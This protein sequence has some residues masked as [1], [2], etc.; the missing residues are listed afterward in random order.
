MAEPERN[1]PCPC[2]SGKKYKKCC[3][4]RS[5][6]GGDPDHLLARA[7]QAFETG[8]SAD[9]LALGRALLRRVPGSVPGH[10]L[11]GLALYRN[12]DAGQARRHLEQALQL[13]PG[14]AQIHS[15]LTLVLQ[16]LGDLDAAER[17]ALRA[18]ALDPAL[19]DAHNNLGNVLKAKGLADEAI[20]H[21]RAATTADPGNPLFLVNLGSLLQL[22]GQRE[23]AETVYRRVIAL[24]PAWAPAHANLGALYLEAKRYQE[25]ET[26]LHQAL[27]HAPDDTEVL[28]NLGLAMQGLGRLE[29]AL[30]WFRRATERDPR[31]AGAHSNLGL[32]LE[33]LGEGEQ[34]ILAY[35]RAVACNPEFYSAHQNLLGVLVGLG[36]VDRAHP[37]ACAL[38]ERPHAET[39]LPVAIDVFGQACDFERRARA[40]RLFDDRWR[41]G[42]IAPATLA[43]AL[44]SG[45]Y[46]SDLTEERLFDYHRAWGEWV[47]S[48]APATEAA[49]IRP[50]S[51]GERLRIAYLS[52]DFRQ[53]PV[54]YFI[55]HVLAAHDRARF[56]VICYSNARKHDSLTDFIRAHADRF[57]TVAGLSDEALAGTIRG[58]GVDILVD[59]AGHTSGNRLPVLALRP[60]PQQMT[61]IGYLNTTGLRAVDYRI[62][63]PYADPEQGVLGTERLLRLP[64]CFLSFG[65]FPTGAVDPQPACLRHGHVTFASFNNLMKLTAPAVRLWADILKRVEG[66]RLVIM[67][68][69]AGSQTVRARLRA[70][71]AGHGVD[72][73]RLVLKESLSR[74]AY[75]D[76]HNTIDVMLD[77]FPYNGGTVTC[78]A[79][80]MGVPVVTRVGTAHRQ[81]VSYSLLKNVGLDETI[82]WDDRQYVEAA[83]RLAGDP[84]ALARLRRELP[85]RLRTSVLGD[86]ARFTRQL[87][88]A[89]LR[90]WEE[91]PLSGRPESSPAN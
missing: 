8:R 49:R 29:E 33:E 4:A 59:L 80:C 28:N 71:F 11:C 69:G 74:E 43:K 32:V 10:H 50:R 63:D 9:A 91:R 78:G 30:A 60:A 52:P 1:S 64:E 77:S 36:Q 21:Y 23:H 41:A 55:Q 15:N 83:V 38:L 6:A 19:A 76:F 47:E 82:A 84:T 88:A 3:G 16:Q 70:E 75:F 31:H 53:H 14:N 56:E 86:T 62:S 13:E 20:D 58:D 40:W 66:S 39:A 42:R 61:W 87:E 67:A 85:G 79:L 48:H 7:T 45:N 73:E 46:E 5:Q 2:G 27:T 12:G 65:D 81:R 35:E 68:V 22:Q 57:T 17:H 34:A 90:V 26:A 54:G 44:F 72:P 24:A 89:Y 18:L 51:A 37:L 25:A